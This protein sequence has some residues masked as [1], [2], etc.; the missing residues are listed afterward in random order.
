MIKPGFT[1]EEHKR[2]GDLLKRHRD[3]LNDLLGPIQKAYTLTGK[4]VQSYSRLQ[5]ANAALRSALDDLS[6]KEH[7]TTA[8]THW[9]Y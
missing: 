7:G 6:Y 9:Y 2:V 3:E 8:D 5:K 1:E 4:V